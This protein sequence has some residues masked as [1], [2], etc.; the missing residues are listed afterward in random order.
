MALGGLGL[1]AR[2]AHL[3]AL[4]D[5]G[6]SHLSTLLPAAARLAPAERLQVL[7]GYQFVIYLLLVPLMIALSVT[8]FS[9][10]EERRS[11]TL[12]PLLATPVR[13]WE[14][15]VGKALAGWLP[16]LGLTWLCA[17]LFVLGFSAFASRTAMTVLLGPAWFVS[18]LLLTPL[19]ALLALF[20]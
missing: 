11:H 7:I 18:L 4:L 16:A 2:G 9:I 15:L 17:L 14:L 13:T 5:R 20:L 3:P 10:F 12:E 8:T 19:I 6:I 1:A